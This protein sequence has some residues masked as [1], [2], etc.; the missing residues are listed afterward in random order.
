MTAQ[1]RRLPTTMPRSASY[2]ASSASSPRSV[3]QALLAPW[4]Y[5][6]PSREEYQ[7][8]PARE[9]DPGLPSV[10]AGRAKCVCA[11]ARDS[12]RPMHG[13]WVPHNSRLSRETLPR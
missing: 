13:S 4:S 5:P 7:T 10:L 9:G 11:L 3:A 12:G 8:L 6:T 1:P 2:C